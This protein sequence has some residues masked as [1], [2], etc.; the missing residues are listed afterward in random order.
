MLFRFSIS[1]ISFFILSLTASA[2]W[3]VYDVRITPDEDSSVN[4]N[5]Y[6]GIY[7]IAPVESGPTTMVFATENAGRVYAVSRDAGRYFIAANAQKRRAVFSS[8]VID[9]TVHAMYQATGALNGTLSYRQKGERR[10]ARIPLEMKGSFMASDSETNVAVP[11]TGDIGVAG[12]AALDA[13]F[14][15][16]L[17]RIVQDQQDQSQAN[18]INVVA[19]LLEKY[20]YQPDTEPLPSEEQTLDPTLNPQTQTAFQPAATSA[21]ADQSAPAPAPSEPP[22]DTSAIINATLFPTGS[23]EEMERALK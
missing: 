9:G 10:A 16:D 6:T 8:I 2:Q 4:F 3:M 7:L 19:G 1:A 23:R 15:A 12:V 22:A 21:S 18:A 11:E 20:G 14:R 13:V 5:A 17:T